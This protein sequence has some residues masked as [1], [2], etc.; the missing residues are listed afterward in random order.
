MRQAALARTTLALAVTVT[1]TALGCNALKLADDPDASPSST[2]SDAE[3]GRE[4]PIDGGVS[5]ADA[6]EAAVRDL[7]WAMWRLPAPS[8]PDSDYSVTSGTVHDDRTSLDWERVAQ[9]TPAA[10]AAGRSYCDALSLEGHDDW[11]LPTRIELL[12]LV[13]YG[14][15][16][17]ALNA[18]VFSGASEAGTYWTAS[19]SAR[20]PS[21]AAWTLAFGTGESAL[22]VA[23]SARRVRC[24]RGDP[25]P[26]RH[27]ELT[28]DVAT[29][30]RT[31][32]A[33]QRRLASASA[34]TWTDALLLCQSAR[35]GDRPGWRLPSARELESIADVR[36][37]S[38]PTWSAAAFAPDE[39]GLLLWSISSV[40]G[41]SPPR[42]RVVDFAFEHATTTLEQTALAFVRCVSAP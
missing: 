35:T 20:D 11:R 9:A 27:Y 19:V 5:G 12:S 7:E 8:P 26:Q 32:L 36:A 38:A 37:S 31:G 16:A 41:A 29:D 18:V 28:A 39:A 25:A 10:W 15:T 22:A 3:A 24:V 23:S 42:A 13:D 14:R 6:G 4:L 30:A 40:V 1:L 34:V 17:P 33:W 2:P 21:S